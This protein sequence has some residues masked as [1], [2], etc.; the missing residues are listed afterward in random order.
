MEIPGDQDSS[1]ATSRRTDLGPS[2]PRSGLRRCLRQ[3]AVA[4][5]RLLGEK[6]IEV[7]GGGEKD[8]LEE[9]EGDAW[10]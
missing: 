3:A 4:A 5:R 6:N 2:A 1:E 10:L 7:E 9:E 8:M